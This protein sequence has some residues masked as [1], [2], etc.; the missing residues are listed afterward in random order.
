MKPNEFDQNNSD[1]QVKDVY[2]L[3]GTI[4]GKL[5]GLVEAQSK[6]IYALIALAAATLGLKLLGTPPLAIISRYIN[7]FVFMFAIILAVGK[8]KSIHGWY[9]VLIYGIFGMLGNI[10][11]LIFLNHE[12]LRTSLFIVANA[13][14]GI[15][16][17]NWDKWKKGSEENRE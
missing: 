4:S 1:P 15:F 5:D 16:L 17:W 8:R 11:Y 9:Y 13:G 14:I 3:L 6:T 7:L 10:Y 2:Y 12:W